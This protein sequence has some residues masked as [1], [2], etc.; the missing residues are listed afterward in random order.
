MYIE[1]LNTNTGHSFSIFV[2]DNSPQQS[3]QIT[4]DPI[5]SI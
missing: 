1:K 2:F 5:M 3:N 4:Y